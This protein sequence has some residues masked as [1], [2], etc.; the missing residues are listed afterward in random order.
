MSANPFQNISKIED[1]LWEAADQLRAN[2]KLTSSE[3]C[4]P[5]LGVIFL[6]HASNRY[7]AALK[8]I[9]A[10]QEAGKMPPRALVKGDFIK[11]RALMLPATA[12]YNHLLTLPAG[13]D[14][15]AALVDAMDAIE[16][17]FEPLA[18]QLPKDYDRFDNEL[19][20]NLLRK[21]DSEVL[22][23][24]SGDVFGRIY[25]Y[26]L[27]KFAIQGA[28]DNG[29]FFTPPSLVQTLV[30]VIEP[31]H[32]VVFDP[33]CGSGGMF[34]QTSHFIEDEGLETMKRVTF[35][36]QEKTATTIRLAKMNLAVH[37]LEGDIQEA[38]S[39]YDDKHRLPDGRA[40]WGNC[41]F[42]MANPPFN[43][44]KVDATKV[45]NDRRLPFGLPGTTNKDKEVSNGNY[46]WISYFHSY[47]SETGRAGFVMSS[48][49]SSAGHGEKE[50]RRK[51]VETGD[52]D[53]MIA[54][55]SNFFYT[56]TV[57]CEL[58]HF[59]RAK[60]PERKDKVLMLD[61][62]HIYRKVTRKIY[63]FSPEQQ[64]SL[65]A[66]VWLYR[67][68][69]ERFVELVQQHISSAINAAHTCFLD[70][71]G[72]K[73]CEPLADFVSSYTA[74][75]QLMKPFLDQLP[76][77]TPHDTALGEYGAIDNPSDPIELFRV[78]TNDIEGHWIQGSEGMADAV[79]VHDNLLKGFV[80]HSRSLI[81]DLD[82]AFKIT[83]RT[84]ELCEKEFAAKDS[85]DWN[86]RE[87]NKAR[88]AADAA[89]HAAVERLKQIRYFQRHAAWLIERFPDAELRDVPGL[90]KLVSRADIEAA[91][92][93]LTPGR[94]VGVAP[95]EVDEDFDF[96]QTMRDLHTELADLNREA[97]ELAARIQENFEGLGV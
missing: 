43:V 93:S 9:K 17:D 18:G 62:R 34:V 8:A 78:F 67:G 31:D 22:R 38:N 1:S 61:A 44:D 37:G 84:I 75:R 56:R 48:Q 45:K 87:I 59:D 54:I 36:G 55:R 91:D 63:D 60:P 6:R 81:A 85:P 92:W 12:H 77:G 15:G 25:E 79:D 86:S 57:P 73:S 24:A 95:A 4:M 70:E 82:H 88:K 28:Q 30:N 51:L 53:V 58:W 94:Y 52:V 90:C 5:V 80:D 65:A 74:L 13:T 3:Y 71:T 35:Y 49:A 33:A 46:L 39:F 42:V 69:R 41:D 40:L 23:S 89:R 27:M 64:A 2:S 68:Q 11:R 16:A 66:I 20:E 76:E 26:F 72:D 10:D 21:F 29:E 83:S 7:D 96:E 19:L 32:G 97:A 47:L 14:L 50:V